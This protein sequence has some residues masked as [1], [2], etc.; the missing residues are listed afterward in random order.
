MSEPTTPAP[1]PD[2]MATLLDA[3][4]ELGARIGTPRTGDTMHPWTVLRDA[5]GFKVVGLTDLERT[6]PARLHASP[7]FADAASFS[8]YVQTFQPDP[9]ARVYADYAN[10]CLVAVL[11]DHEPPEV[12]RDEEADVETVRLPAAPRWRTHRAVYA[13]EP[14]DEWAKWL[15]GDRRPM[16]Q[17]EMAEHLDDLLYTV[18]DP[19]PE[20]L[21]GVVTGLVATKEAQFESAVRLDNGETQFQYAE[22]VKG[23]TRAGL[24]E[25]PS[26]FTVM[27]PVYHGMPPAI[28]RAAFRYRIGRDGLTLHY[29]LQQTARLQREAWAALSEEVRNG[30]LPVPVLQGRVN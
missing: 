24:M 16:G 17:V 4:R 9:A 28:L 21:R 7:V 12:V 6:R 26:H 22:N 14:S 2:G 15:A 18:A 3:G 5:K 19:D 11:D 29:A 13:V 25:I 8:A 10:M 27:A 1:R 23:Q 30:V 20:T